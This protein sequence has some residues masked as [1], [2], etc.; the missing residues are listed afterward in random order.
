MGTTQVHK[1]REWISEA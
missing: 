1:H